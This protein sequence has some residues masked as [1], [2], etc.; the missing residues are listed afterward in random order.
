MLRCLRFYPLL[1]VLDCQMN[2]RDPLPS[3]LD[4]CFDFSDIFKLLSQKL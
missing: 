1:I 4:T 3:I 2:L